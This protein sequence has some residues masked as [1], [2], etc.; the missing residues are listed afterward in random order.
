[1][2]IMCR[3]RVLS[4]VVF[5][6]LALACNKQADHPKSSSNSASETEHARTTDAHPTPPT[7]ADS[8]GSAMTN[9]HDE[10]TGA[11]LSG[12]ALQLDGL[13]M[14][15]PDGWQ[16]GEIAPGPFAPVAVFV[17]PKADED[18]EGGQVR[19]THYPNMKGKDDMNIQRW[20]GQVTKDD[21][22]SYSL[23]DANLTV[24]ESGHVR[25]KTID[26][27]GNV[28]ATM[29]ETPRANSRMIAAIVDHPQGPHFIVSSGGAATIAKNA[30][31]IQAFLDSAK[32]E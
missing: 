22:S 30:D 31:S 24:K 15:V 27:T 2:G 5:L 4:A 14:T 13:T 25:I 28:K 29:R 7:H 8:H 26:V 23:D 1:M 17:M 12:S 16:K 21:G 32:V 11:A 18:T 10:P 6:T 19:I 9:P 3:T 20:L